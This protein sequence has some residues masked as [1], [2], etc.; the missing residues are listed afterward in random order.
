MR[1]IAYRIV[2][3]SVQLQICVNDQVIRANGDVELLEINLEDTN[4]LSDWGGRFSKENLLA[5][6]ELVVRVS[7]WN[8]DCSEVA[9]MVGPLE[10]FS[11]FLAA[12]FG[13][14]MVEDIEE[15]PEVVNVEETE[16]E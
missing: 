5:S 4:G 11:A 16:S 3:A 7:T 6:L 8:R 14:F 12:K 9:A 2:N 13:V 1:N 10:V 15:A